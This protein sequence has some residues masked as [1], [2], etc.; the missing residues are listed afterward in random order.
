MSLI[1]LLPD[2]D[3]SVS[4]MR[5]VLLTIPCSEITKQA[6]NPQVCVGPGLPKAI[7]KGDPGQVSLTRS[8]F[9]A[10]RP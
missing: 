1:T 6:C 8:H 5:T 4:S 10:F 3:R 7:S 9:D 2:L